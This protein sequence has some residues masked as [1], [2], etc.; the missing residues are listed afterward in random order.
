MAA[1]W[2]V[3]KPAL[4]SRKLDDDK[5][6][7]GQ[8]AKR[9]ATKSRTQDLDFNRSLY[10]D[11]AA[12]IFTSLTD[13]KTGGTFAHDSFAKFGLQVHLGDRRDE[14]PKSK[15]EAMFV[16]ARNSDEST[17]PADFDIID[18]HHFVPFKDSFKY[19]RTIITSDLDD[20]V[21]IQA[22]KRQALAAFA[23]MEPIF[24]DRK[25]KL[26]SKRRLYLHR[27]VNILLWGCES[28]AL[29]KAQIQILRSTHNY[30]V[31]EICGLTRWHCKNYH[32]SMKIILE[33]ARLFDIEPMIDIRRLRFMYK[34]ARNPNDLTFHMLTSQGVSPTGTYPRGAVKTTLGAMKTSLINAGLIEDGDTTFNTWMK[35]LRMPRR[36]LGKLIDAGLGVPEGSF[37]RE[38]KPK[39][40]S[41]EPVTVASFFL[42]APSLSQ[43]MA[44]VRHTHTH[45]YSVGWV[46]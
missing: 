14:K 37:A 32:L 45:F 36:K 24:K 13:L 15:T 30:C 41:R 38:A 17:T 23:A 7:L 44:R 35:K 34:V 31:R 1:G 21:D 9:D 20:T 22:R 46:R 28:W 18:E 29:T 4:K 8:F 16:P 26:E 42:S 25:V 2:P 6:P 12:F 27:I 19:L 11:D 10:A 5:I 43:P 40:K 33:R 3:K 39:R